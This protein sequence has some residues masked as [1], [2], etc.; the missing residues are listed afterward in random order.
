MKA[1]RETNGCPLIQLID[2]SKVYKMGDT[3]VRANDRINLTIMPGE[4]VAIVGKSGS[5][6]STLMNIIGLLDTPTSGSYLLKGQDV[7][8][9]MGDRLAE[10]RNKT[11]GFIFQQY[12]LLPKQTLLENVELPLLYANYSRKERHQRARTML[13]KVGLNGKYKNKPGQ[14]SGGQQQRATIA[15]AL[16]GSPSII[17][18]DEPTGSLDSRTSKDV[19]DFLKQLH[20]EGNTIIIVTHDNSIATQARRI[21]KIHDGKVVF[22]DS[23]ELYH[24]EYHLEYS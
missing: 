4:F 18:A 23:A 9:M 15:R 8:K 19:L 12:N 1:V 11:I 20:E 16:A 2:I 5:G 3:I 21:I 17:L 24:P 6:K 22:D 7:S 14:L 10:I 13:D